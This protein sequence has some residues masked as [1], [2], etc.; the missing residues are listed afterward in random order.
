MANWVGS[1]HIPEQG[2]FLRCHVL[3]K[4]KDLCFKRIKNFKHH[5]FPMELYICQLAF[6]RQSSNLQK[7]LWMLLFWGLIIFLILEII[8]S[9][10]FR[11]S[12]KCTTPNRSTFILLYV[13]NR[14]K[15]NLILVHI[16]GVF[17][18]YF[19]HY[20]QEE[21]WCQIPLVRQFLFFYLKK[22]IQ[23]NHQACFLCKTNCT[24]FWFKSMLLALYIPSDRF[25]NIIVRMIIEG[26]L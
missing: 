5:N 16:I 21:E 22:K 14:M 18:Y 9:L 4:R 23:H 7:N 6:Q 1:L 25:F 13:L 19:I 20:Y 15:P 17:L 10:G 12:D 26:K 24:N 3:K 2:A 8:S 11:S